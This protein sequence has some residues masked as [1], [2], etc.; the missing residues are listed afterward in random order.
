MRY[1]E[2]ELPADENGRSQLVPGP[3]VH[4]WPREDFAIVSFPN[5]KEKESH[6]LVLFFDI[7]LY[8]QFKTGDEFYEFWKLNFPSIAHLVPN[9][10][11]RLTFY[12]E[13]PKRLGYL[14]ETECYPWAINKT[15]LIGDSAH[16]MLPFLA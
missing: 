13:N 7:S 2:V 11:E 1:V 12:I 16:A 15:C 3:Y 5:E 9:L 10:K 6:S 14:F 8:N 4:T